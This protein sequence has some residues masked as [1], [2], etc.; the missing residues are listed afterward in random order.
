M[1]KETAVII[2]IIIGIALFFIAI[3]ELSYM[4]AEDQFKKL[5]GEDYDPNENE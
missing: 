1:S 5:T 2:I 3:D 4:R